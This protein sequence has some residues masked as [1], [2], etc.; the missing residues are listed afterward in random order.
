VSIQLVILMPALFSIMFLGMQGALWY[1]ARSVA[2]AA[3]QEGAR[4]A[5]AQNQSVEDGL[6]AA[7]A[8]VADAGG[9]DVLQGATVTG[10]RTATQ[11]TVRVTGTSLSVIPGWSITVVQ[12]ATA[13]VERVTG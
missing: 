1:H 5:G 12:S 6:A 2:I 8:F 11:A 7:S 4:T 3:A 10:T 13:Q 9:D